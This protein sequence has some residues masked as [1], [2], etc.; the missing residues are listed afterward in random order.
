MYKIIILKTSLFDSNTKILT[1]L[2]Y[3]IYE[4][5]IDIQIF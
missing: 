2:F 3:K 5:I 1:K 4:S